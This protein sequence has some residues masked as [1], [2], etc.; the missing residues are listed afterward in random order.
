M[1]VLS[2]CSESSSSAST[3]RPDRVSQ[4]DRS[5]STSTRRAP[6]SPWGLGRGRLRTP[7]SQRQHLPLQGEHL[8]HHDLTRWLAIARRVG[9]SSE[10][11]LRALHLSLHP[12][13]PQRQDRPHGGH[14]H[15]CELMSTGL[16][17]SAQR[18]LCGER[19]AGVTL[20][21]RVCRRPRQHLR[22]TAA[23]H[24]HTAAPSPVETQPGW[25]SDALRTWN[26]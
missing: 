21:H 13:Q 10:A 9:S 14:D 26:D 4:G 6:Q 15:E 24:R 22:R 8:A 12:Y 11:Y 19:A 2:R 18:L 3:T 16:R 17:V 25:R 7:C 1:A 20:A 5:P 23:R